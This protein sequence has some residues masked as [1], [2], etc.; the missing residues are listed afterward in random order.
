M[1][2][3]LVCFKYREDADRSARATHRERLRAL[4]DIDGILDLKVGEDVVRSARSYDTGL[5]VLFRDQSALEQYQVHP[6]HVP[7]AQF[8]VGLCASIVAADFEADR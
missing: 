4:A 7:V 5:V 6:R 3:H 2:V 8:G 1:I